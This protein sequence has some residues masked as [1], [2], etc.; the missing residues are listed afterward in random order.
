MEQV[1]ESYKQAKDQHERMKKNLIKA[2][3]LFKDALSVKLVY[4][5]VIAQ[6]I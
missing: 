6:L 1:Q 2:K 3:N 4:E 5:K